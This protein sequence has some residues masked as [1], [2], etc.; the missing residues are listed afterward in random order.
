MIPQRR[1][2]APNTS[3]S[4]IMKLHTRTRKAILMSDLQPNID[5]KSDC[6]GCQKKTKPLVILLYRLHYASSMQSWQSSGIL[7]HPRWAHDVAAF[8]L[9]CQDFFKNSN[10][11]KCNVHVGR[12]FVGSVSR[13]SELKKTPNF[14]CVVSLILTL[15]CSPWKTF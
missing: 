13:T 10:G 4:L 1:D 14:Q 12:A 5:Y 6:R 15:F 2:T 9:W 7:H 11:D 8:S 3:P